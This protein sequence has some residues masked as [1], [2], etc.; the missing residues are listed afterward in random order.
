LSAPRLAGHLSVDDSA[1]RIRNYRYA[2]ERMMRVLDEELG[3]RRRELFSDF[4]EC[5]IGVAS[6]G[7]V[8]RCATLAA[9]QP[10]SSSGAS[11]L[12]TAGHTASAVTWT[13]R[14]QVRASRIDQSSAEARAGLTA[15]RER[16]P[17]S[18]SPNV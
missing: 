5:P 6:I 12:A 13:T 3:G 17:L 9:A 2:E 11:A 1:R 7:Q 8:W 14:Y 16:M 18:T 4:D 10:R 15:G